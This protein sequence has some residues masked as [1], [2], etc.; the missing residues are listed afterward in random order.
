MTII[1]N[2][3]KFFKLIQLFIETAQNNKN[4]NQVKIPILEDEE[5]GLTRNQIPVRGSNYSQINIGGID[6]HVH[7][8]NTSSYGPTKGKSSKV[9][10]IDY[11]SGGGHWKNIRAVWQNNK[12]VSL[13]VV[14]WLVNNK[15]EELDIKLEIPENFLEIEKP[16]KEFLMFYESYTEGSTNMTNDLKSK[17]INSKNIVLHGAPG[18][19]KTYLAKQIAKSLGATKENEQ[20]EFVQFHPSYDYTDFVEGLRPTLDTSENGQLGFE[21]R[22]GT[23]K[24]FCERA[25]GKIPKK[26]KS[27]DE[28]WE[29][30]IENEVSDK[31][32]EINNYQFHQNS[33]GNITY[34][35]PGGST[36][37][38][39]LENVK[40]YLENKKWGFKNYHSTY[41]QPIYDTYLK[42]KLATIDLVEN[43]K[44]FVF[45][46]DEI[47]RGEISKIFG[48]LF[49]AIDPEYRGPAGAVKTQYANLH[50]E[51]QD[52]YVPDNVYI[53]G[54]MNDIDRSVESFDFAMR[55]RFSFIELKANENVNWLKDEEKKAQLIRLNQVIDEIGLS[56]AYH[57]GAAYLNHDE[58]WSDYLKPLFESYFDGQF[59]SEEITSNLI[60]LKVAFDNNDEI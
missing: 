60:K 37:S 15:D 5:L 55:R 42:E 46:I 41:K 59:S 26:G 9:P 44:N 25:K 18:T 53:I 58:P 22:D 1:D 28:I 50:T 32:I 20:L 30:F 8:F 33:K 48:E 49:F 14:N 13:K 7:M 12:I 21:L 31:V 3:I 34:E 19:G 51:E 35:V 24:E 39:T 23:F 6:Y 17:L 36:A 40:Y 38:L 2:E 54:T 45:I 47:N 56:S 43:D 16:D 4:I 57:V 11:D 10:Y 52:F 27:V 29:N